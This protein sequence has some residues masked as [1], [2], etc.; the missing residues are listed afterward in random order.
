MESTTT[1]TMMM[2]MVVVVVAIDFVANNHGRLV[3]QSACDLAICKPAYMR[4]SPNFSNHLQ[5][6]S[7][8]FIFSNH[9]RQSFATVIVN[10]HFQ[11]SSS[12]FIFSNHFQQSFSTIIFNNHFLNATHHGQG[13]GGRTRSAS[14][15][16]SG[17]GASGGNT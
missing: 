1:T 7:S 9:C 17:T 5:Q 8:I 13:G 6:S 10:I 15:I 14:T 3:A 16:H 12:T 2:M 11:Q 4:I